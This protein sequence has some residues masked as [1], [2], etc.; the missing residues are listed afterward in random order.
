MALGHG[1]TV[2]GRGA[3]IDPETFASRQKL[4]D[5]LYKGALQNPPQ[6]E[7]S[8]TQGAARL[9]QAVA[10]GYERAGVNKDR[11]AYKQQR[12]QDMQKLGTALGTGD[13]KSVIGQLSDPDSQMMAFGLAKSDMDRQNALQG[14]YGMKMFEHGLKQDDYKRDRG[15]KIQ[16]QE[17]Q[18]SH[19]K[20]MQNEN[21]KNF[22]PIEVQRSFS[23]ENDPNAPEEVRKGAALYRD[24]LKAIQPGNTTVN[25]YMG[26]ATSKEQERISG[27]LGKQYEDAQI[28][29][30]ALSKK[31]SKIDF[32]LSNLDKAK[33]G[34]LFETR[35]EAAT[36]IQ[37]LGGNPE[38]LGL[39]NAT[40][41]SV[42]GQIL[43]QFV[44]E[45]MANQKGPQTDPDYVRILKSQ[46][47][48]YETPEQLRGGLNMLKAFNGRSI[49]YA[50]RAADWFR[51]NGSLN[52][53]VNNM[54]F[55]Q[56][57]R[58]YV[59]ANPLFVGE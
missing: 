16:D 51:K 41:M 58:S 22:L 35:Q 47:Q 26:K 15:D 49:E 59:N 2:M 20:E 29:A 18:F 24:K 38:K 44:L 17:R 45:E 55:D 56:A 43:R 33:P 19:T 7:L 5:E 4:A 11:D 10:S 13:Y 1:I 28:E 42:V 32:I 37:S 50:D 6:P 21:P 12:L 53:A 52:T 36:V 14:Q 57:W 48:A 3:A 27:G 34:P 54:N 39:G 23:I 46:P 31:N 30:K 8:W 25:N 40:S 9:A